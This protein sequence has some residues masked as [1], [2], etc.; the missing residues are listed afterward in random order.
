M[1]VMPEMQYKCVTEEKMMKK[2][3]KRLLLKIEV[4]SRQVISYCTFLLFTTVIFSAVAGNTGFVSTQPLF[5]GKYRCQVLVSF[6]TTFLLADEYISLFYVCFSL[7]TPYLICSIDSLTLNLWPLLISQIMSF[8][9]LLQP[10]VQIWAFA[11]LMQ[12][13]PY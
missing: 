6:F 13:L 5:P 8:T 1:L 12:T 10:S 2:G 7:K 3:N 11:L 9:L 4:R